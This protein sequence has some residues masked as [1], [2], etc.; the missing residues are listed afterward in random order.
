MRYILDAV[1]PLDERDL[2]FI[3]RNSA[4]E[5]VNKVVQITKLHAK[6]KMGIDD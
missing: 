6:Q 4:K 5:Y 2:A 3:T 1:G